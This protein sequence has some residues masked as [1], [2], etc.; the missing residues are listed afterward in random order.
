MGRTEAVGTRVGRGIVALAILLLVAGPFYW[1][2]TSSFKSRQEVIA[3]PPTVLPHRPSIEGYRELFATTPY[4][5]YLKNSTLVALLTMVGSLIVAVLAGVAIYRLRI[6]G[7][8]ALETIILLAYVTPLTLLIVPIF[9]VMATIGLLNTHWSLVLVNMTFV[10]PFSVW[11]MRGFLGAIPR[12]L[13]EAAALDGAPWYVIVWN[14]ILPLMLP[15][16]SAIA[17]YAFIA[18]WTE[19]TFASILIVSDHLKTLPVGIGEIMGQYYVRWDLLTAAAVLTSLP[20]VVLFAII[21][22]WFVGGLITGALR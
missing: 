21:G 17:I 6:R 11:L 2:A 7:D 22:R 1:V 3:I 20:G 9:E 19:F 10:V 14:I 12:D 18:S 8:Q 15:G 4:L 5:T 13:D 16:M